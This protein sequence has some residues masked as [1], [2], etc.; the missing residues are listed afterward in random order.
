MQSGIMQH[1]CS[2]TEALMQQGSGI[3]QATSQ[4]ACSRPER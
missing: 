1:D 3:K 4:I 2:E